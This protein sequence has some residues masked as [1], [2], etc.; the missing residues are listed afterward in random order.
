MRSARLTTINSNEKTP[1]T[2]FSNV[3]DR[4]SALFFHRGVKKCGRKV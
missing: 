2:K 1:N 4:A 3:I